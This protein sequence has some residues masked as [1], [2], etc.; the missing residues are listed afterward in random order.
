MLPAL[1]ALPFPRSASSTLDAVPRAVRDLAA[2]P[3]VFQSRAYVP[4]ALPTFEASRTKLPR[5]VVADHPEWI[6]LYWKAW[7]L[8][9]SNL[10]QPEPKSGFISNFIDPAFNGNTFQWDTLFMLQFAHYAEPTFHAIG[11]LDNFYKKAHADGSICREISRSSGEDFVFGSLADTVNPPLFSWVEWRNYLLSGD[12]SRFRDILPP[13]V[14]HYLWLQ[15]NRRREDG[16]YWNTGLGA[17]EDDPARNG[18]AY[19]WVDMTAQQAQNAYFI[20]RIAGQ[21]G[22]KRGAAYFEEENNRTRRS[23]GGRTWCPPSPPTR[24]A[25]PRT[26]NTGTAP[27]G[28]RR[29]TSSSRSWRNTATRISPRA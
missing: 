1:L 28:R 24:R 14:K 21:I 7:A 12:E 18:S 17:G 20:A 2:K 15:A 16:L 26:A 8:A 23:S 3:N 19:S 5:P 27:S 13:L 10:K 11:S 22:E 6:D 25:T 4:R 29:T 9:F